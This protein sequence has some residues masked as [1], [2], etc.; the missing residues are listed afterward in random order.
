MTSVRYGNVRIEHEFSPVRARFSSHC[1]AA[2]YFVRVQ[3]MGAA[4][5]HYVYWCW[6]SSVEGEFLENTTDFY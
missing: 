4:A 2:L 3:Y 6:P 1:A 5:E